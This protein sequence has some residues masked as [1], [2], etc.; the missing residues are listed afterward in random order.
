MR[1]LELERGFN[2]MASTSVRVTEETWSMIKDLAAKTNTSMQDVIQQAI[3]DYRRKKILEETNQAFL[4][5]KNNPEAWQDELQERKE[6]E[7]TI[8][9]NQ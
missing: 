5:L 3:E 2:T 7:N 8:G 1:I 4:R 9:D 6:W